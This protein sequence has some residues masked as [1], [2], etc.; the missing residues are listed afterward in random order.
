MILTLCISFYLPLTTNLLV[1]IKKEK[2]EVDL[3]RVAYEQ[4]QK[5]GLNQDL[6]STW[7]T[8]KTHYIITLSEISQRKGIHIHYG[9]QTKEMDI[10][11]T[12]IITP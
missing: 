9:G 4:S 7:Q 5:I 1:T 10:L 6:D 3:A 12:Q 2:T 8:G 11:S